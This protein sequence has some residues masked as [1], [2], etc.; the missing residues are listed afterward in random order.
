VSGSPIVTVMMVSGF[1]TSAKISAATAKI[2]MIQNLF[3]FSTPPNEC[4][5]QLIRL[6]KIKV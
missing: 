6:Q 2:A 4:I 5:A 1:L 3:I